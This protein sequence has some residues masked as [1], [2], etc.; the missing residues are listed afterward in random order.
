M[1]SPQ[2]YPVAAQYMEYMTFHG[3][4]YLTLEEFAVRQELY[5]QTDDLIKAHNATDSS[6][7]LGHN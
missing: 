7:K 3:K 2:L 6:F 4:S 1:L 5:K